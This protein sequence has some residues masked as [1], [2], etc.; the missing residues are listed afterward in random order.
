MIIRS[1]NPDSHRYRA[2]QGSA[3]VSQ[4]V[5]LDTETGEFTRM[6]DDNE[7]EKGVA[8]AVYYLPTGKAQWE[9]ING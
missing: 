8:D 6:G 9:R 5:S 2:R 1:S 4:L 7:L 3:W